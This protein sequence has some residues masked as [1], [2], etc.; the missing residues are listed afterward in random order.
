M[1]VSVT[2]DEADK[3]RLDPAR[4]F[5]PYEVHNKQPGKRYKMLN[6]SERNLERRK[7]E[8]YE[9]VQG[10]DPE[11]LGLNEST[12]LKKGAD[13]D[14]TRRFS[15]LVLGRISEELVE[16]KAKKNRELVEHRTRSVRNQFQGEVG[17]RAFEERGSGGGN[18]KYA[19]SMSEGEFD[20]TQKG[21]K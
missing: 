13:V 9:I 15:D 8:G 3:K 20:A 17:D 10:D 18:T 14:T 21:K 6:K 5:D 19:G 12:A 4:K 11:K 7:A 2:Q 1:G 16:Q